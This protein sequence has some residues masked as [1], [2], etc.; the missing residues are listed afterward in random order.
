VLKIILHWEEGGNMKPVIGITSYY[1]KAYEIEECR[2]RG[3][4]GQDMVMST[5]DYPRAV[6]KAGGIPFIIPMIN[7]IEF[8]EGVV[9]K[10]D[11]LILSGGPDI[12]PLLYDSSIHIGCK[13][14]VAER[15]RFELKILGKAIEHDKPVFGICKG[16]HMLN[17]F[18]G[19]TLYQDIYLECKTNIAHSGSKASSYEPCHTVYFEENSVFDGIYNNKSYVNSYHHQAIKDIGSELKAVGWSTDDNLIEAIIHK[20]NDFILGVQW[21]PEMMASHYEE[22]LEIFKYFINL[23]RRNKHDQN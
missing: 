6:E 10:I 5:I 2:P 18:Y 8:I 19:G 14:T 9:E 15:D 20:N 7:N 17:I 11:G 12:Y 16:F 23:I 4:I 22:Q 13:K 21:H 3:I 1:V